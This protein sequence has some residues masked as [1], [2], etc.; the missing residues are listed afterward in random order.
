MFL[1]LVQP[2]LLMGLVALVGPDGCMSEMKGCRTSH[3]FSSCQGGHQWLLPTWK[4]WRVLTCIHGHPT[5][6]VGDGRGPTFNRNPY[7]GNIKPLLLGWWP[8]PIIRNN[9]SLYPSTHV[10]S[11]KL[12][13]FSGTSLR[14]GTSPWYSSLPAAAT[15]VIMILLWHFAVRPHYPTNSLN[16]L[17]IVILTHP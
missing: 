11:I 10:Q 9:G 13:F 7:N 12:P 5:P 14:S 2:S 15:D 6:Y 8:S 4:I 1:K 16:F 17:L 3:L